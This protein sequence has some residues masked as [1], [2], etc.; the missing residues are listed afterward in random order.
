M[1]RIPVGHWIFGR[2]I[3][4]IS[5]WRSSHHLLK[6]YETLD[7]AF[8][9]AEEYGLNIVLDLHAAPGCQNGFDNGES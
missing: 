4:T 2:I 6:A 7:R 1:R 8:D 3:R 9:W 5:L